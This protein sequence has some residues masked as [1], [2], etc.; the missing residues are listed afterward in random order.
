MLIALDDPIWGRLY[1]PYGVE[2]V[3]P[4]LARLDAGWD[5]DLAKDLF[6]ER[7]HH[8]ETRCPVTYAALPWLWRFAQ[9]GD[10]G[11][12]EYLLFLS[13]VLYCATAESEEKYR[14]LTLAPEA[15][16]KAWLDPAVWLTGEDMARLAEIEAWLTETEPAIVEACLDALKEDETAVH[17]AI[18]PVARLGGQELAWSL[19]MWADG[20]EEGELPDPAGDPLDAAA[21]LARRIRPRNATLAGFLGGRAARRDL[22][23]A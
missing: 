7:L 9:R 11:R 10:A 19:Q 8:Q 21:A 22:P 3:A 20:E 13:W 18:G 1:G 4:P 6:W 23:K 14:G 16:R 15:H 2:E 5:A 12:A 17:F